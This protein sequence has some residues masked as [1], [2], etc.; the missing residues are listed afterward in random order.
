MFVSTSLVLA[1]TWIDDFEDGKLDDVWGEFD[2]AVDT[3]EKGEF[4]IRAELRQ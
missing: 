1:G 3:V 4:S 2:P